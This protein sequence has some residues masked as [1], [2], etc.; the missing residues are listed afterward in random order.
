LRSDFLAN[1]A[2]SSS[3]VDTEEVGSRGSLSAVSGTL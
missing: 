3:Y 1:D 2:M